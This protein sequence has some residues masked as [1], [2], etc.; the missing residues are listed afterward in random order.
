MF[1]NFFKY[2]LY[3]TQVEN[4]HYFSSFFMSKWQQITL[5]CLSNDLINTKL[6]YTKLCHTNFFNV[7]YLCVYIH[8]QEY[9]NNISLARSHCLRKIFNFLR[10]NSLGQFFD[11]NEIRS[12]GIGEQ[13]LMKQHCLNYTRVRRNTYG[14]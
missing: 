12:Y 11:G 4:W 9:K 10:F 7:L 1:Q 8:L 6:C 3:A 13:P 5:V 14:Y 2:T